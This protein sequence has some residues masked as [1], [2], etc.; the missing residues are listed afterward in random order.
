MCDSG[1]TH[2]IAF[3]S[4]ENLDR[5]FLFGTQK[6]S[7]MMSHFQNTGPMMRLS[8]VNTKS[9]NTNLFT[10]ANSKYQFYVTSVKPLAVK[11]PDRLTDHTDLPRITHLFQTQLQQK[12][13][14]TETH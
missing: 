8:I 13:T 12:E 11:L 9:D 4:K 3:A 1:L 14:Q 5:H 7:E 6:R 10:L 2:S